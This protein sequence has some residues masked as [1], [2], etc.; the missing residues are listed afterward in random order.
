MLEMLAA[1][2]RSGAVPAESALLGISGLNEDIK[3][4]HF[5]LG[6]ARTARAIASDA[7]AFLQQNTLTPREDGS[8][9][10]EA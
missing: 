8:H 7:L 6:T 9:R 4:Y 5:G 3:I 10:E 2:I 1:D